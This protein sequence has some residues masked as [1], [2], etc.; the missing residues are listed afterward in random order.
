MNLGKSTATIFVT[1]MMDEIFYILM[2]PLVIA[3]IGVDNL[4]PQEALFE[5]IQPEM[6]KLLFYL[7]YGFIV[8]LTLLIL[9]GIF[10][11]PEQTKRFLLG[12]FSLRLLRR[13]R[14]H[15]EKLGDEIIMSSYELKGKSLAYWSRAFGATIVSWT[16]RFFTLNFIFL[17][18]TSDFNHAVVY[19]R[20]LVMWVI[21]L[22]SITPGSSGIAEVMLPA[23]FGDMN[24]EDPTVAPI[25]LVVIAILWRLFTYFPY[26]FVGVLVLPSWLR[27]T[28]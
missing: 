9:F 17:A 10:F 14:H 24:W 22:I 18:F 4:F 13:W 15:V 12:L 7:G 19:G 28:A 6:F 2:V 16:A 25:L 20:Q 23:F 11:L 26:I 27:R 21:M 3:I 1:A 8:V 5:I